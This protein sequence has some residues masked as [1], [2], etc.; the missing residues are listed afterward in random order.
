LFASDFTCTP[1][2]RRLEHAVPV[3]FEQRAQD[4]TRIGILVCDENCV[5]IH[6]SLGCSVYK[7]TVP[8]DRT[9]NGS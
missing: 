4:D 2:V 6:S 3:S 5:R 8:T 1:G 9:W 7:E